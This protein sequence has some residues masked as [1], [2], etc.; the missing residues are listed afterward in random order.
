L[1][2]RVAIATDE[3]YLSETNI[4]QSQTNRVAVN[5]ATKVSTIAH[6]GKIEDFNP[7]SF[8]SSVG[9]GRTM[10]KITPGQTILCQGDPSPALFYLQSGRV[11]I[12]IISDQG[13]EGVTAL[14]GAG[15]FFGEQSLMRRH[16]HRTNAIATE[17]STIIKINSDA[18]MRVMKEEPTLAMMFL[19]FVLSRNVEIEDDL[20]DHLFNSSEKRL[21][22][23]L[24]KLAGVEED[25]DTETRTKTEGII[26]KMSQEVLASRIGTTR[27]RINYFMNKFRKLGYIDYDREITVRS[28]LVNI[29]SQEDAIG[30]G[31][32]R[33]SA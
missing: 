4:V 1:K 26:P 32:R 2:R 31:D 27:G 9:P 33:K 12:S 3:P 23:L 6:N 13:K 16:T 24:L 22:R 21:A 8:L 30:F 5:T 17:H 7:Q 10:L 19:S 25:G 11:Q 14:H 18:M 28:R 15:E 20:V 29:L